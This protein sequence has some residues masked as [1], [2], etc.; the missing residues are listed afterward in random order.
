MVFFC[1]YLYLQTYFLRGSRVFIVDFERLKDEW[2]C[3][4]CI[5]T[6]CIQMTINGLEHLTKTPL[7]LQ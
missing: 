3:Y 6:M 4:V 7:F 1:L 2:K 5:L